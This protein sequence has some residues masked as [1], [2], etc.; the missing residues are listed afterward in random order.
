MVAL[1]KPPEPTEVIEPTCVDPA[2]AA[3]SVGL[4][5]VHD[6]MPGMVRVATKAGFEFRGPDSSQV[7]DEATLERIR[8]LVIPPAWTDVWICASPTGHLQ[9][10]G[11]DARGRKQ[12]RYHPKW[13]EVRD[14]QK[15]ARLAAFGRRLPLIR[16]RA[17]RD[18]ARA[19]LP[20]AKVLATVVRLLELTLIR[21]GNEEY[22]RSNRSYG[23]T[24]L[25]DN[26]VDVNGTTVQFKFRGKSG[27][28]HRI[29]VRDRR[30]AHIIKR[31]RDLPGQDLFQ[32]VDE[33]GVTQSIGSGDVNDYLREVSEQD[34]TAK[35]FRTWAGT[36]LAAT[37]LHAFGPAE[38]DR[39]AKSNIVQAVGMV[40]ERLGNTPA[41]SRKCYIHPAVVDAYL[42]GELIQVPDGDDG[43]GLIPEERAL[44]ALLESAAV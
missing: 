42:G 9:A 13:R 41:I 21:V 7:D 44:L 4:R 16:E 39:E 36:L 12:Y 6:R 5:Y 31:C 40:A 30:L 32:Y 19:G 34:F 20:R 26:H 25:R 3:R 10:T 2:V 11:R 14:E 33:E 8:S 29:G 37:A 15:Y 22:A 1:A 23:L 28:E 35:D 38:T 27:K 43:S 17:D 24:T 18:L